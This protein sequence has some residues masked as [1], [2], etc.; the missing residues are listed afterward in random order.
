MDKLRAIHYFIASASTG[1]FAK[2]ARH[3]DVTVP[4]VQKM[5]GALE[6]SIGTVL[7][8]RNSRG[9][10]L[11]ASGSDYLES[12]RHLLEG[13]TSA[14]ETLKRKNMGVSGTLVLA[15]HEQLSHQLLI[16][17]LPA[18]H[19][20][21]P[22]IQLDCRTIHR[23]TDGDAEAAEILILHGWP[24]TPAN[25][26]QRN[27]GNARGLILASPDYWTAHGL[28]SCPQELEQHHCLAMRNPAGILIDL[29][30]FKRG[31]EQQAVRVSGPVSSNARELLLEAALRGHGVVRFNEI[32]TRAQ[33]QS[34]QLIPV[35]LDWEV[36]GSPPINLLYPASSRRNPLVRLFLDFFVQHL[37]KME[38]E[39]LYLSQHPSMEKPAW[40]RRGFGRAS[41][42]L[43][44][45][46][47]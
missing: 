46:F 20:R 12:C 17:A 2:A 19:A 29:W 26:V 8:E 21:Y 5:V 18:F 30:E 39:G 13:L 14:E 43:Q 9:V 25:F 16:P 3:L 15:M 27:L 47:S 40:H 42:L 35:L 11:T 4:A 41:S 22:D 34:G 36:M 23:M 37:E 33:V 1:S 45:N 32:T 31:T 10:R 38:A 6:K 7:L 24:E 44:R 28:P